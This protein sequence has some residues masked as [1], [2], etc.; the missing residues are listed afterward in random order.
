MKIIRTV[1]LIPLNIEKTQ[2]CLVKKVSNDKNKGKWSFPGELVKPEE[3]NN[4]AIIRII[5][6]QMKCTVSNFKEFKKTE[7]RVKIAVIKSQYL[8]GNIQGEIKLDSRKYSEFKW[9][10]LNQELL[11]LEY[12]FDENKIVINLLK[13]F[14]K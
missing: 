5:K 1:S 6:A 14:K 12:A 3:S 13:E 11:S 4:Q 10:D 9:F 7:S 8:T 2:I